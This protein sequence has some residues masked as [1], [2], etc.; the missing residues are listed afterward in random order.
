MPERSVKIFRNP[1][2]AGG[3]QAGTTKTPPRNKETQMKNSMNVA[4]WVNE[5]ESLW[6]GLKSGRVK[7]TVAREMNQTASNVIGFAK[8]VVETSRLRGGPPSMPLLGNSRVP[9]K[10]KKAIKR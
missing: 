1:A 2:G 9:R 5:L 6:K 10:I 7:P 8:L 4:E 3:A